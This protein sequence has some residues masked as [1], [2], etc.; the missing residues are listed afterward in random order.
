MAEDEYK[1]LLESVKQHGL[2]HKIVLLDGMILDGRHRDSACLELK[3]PPIYRDYD[4]IIDGDVPVAFVA[5]ENLHRRSLTTSQRAAVAAELEPFFAEAL[6]KQKAARA[7][8]KADK[9]QQQAATPQ[10]QTPAVETPSAAV[11]D[12]AANGGN[13]AAAKTVEEVTAELAEI[14]KLDNTSSVL[15]GAVAR[16]FDK[17]KDE[18]P[19]DEGHP[20][21]EL[22]ERGWVREDARLKELAESGGGTPAGDD[23]DLEIGS[24]PGTSTDD[25]AATSSQEGAGTSADEGEDEKAPK[26]PK[27]AAEAAGAVAGVSPRSVQE[28]K[29]LKEKDPEKFEQVKSGEKSLHKASQEAAAQQQSV[30]PYRQECADLLEASFGEEFSTALKN[31]TVLKTQA[32]L[33]AFMKLTVPH[34]KEVMQFVVK[35]W[36]VDSAIKFL[37]GEFDAGTTLAE[38]TSYANAKGGEAVVEFGNFTITIE[39]S[40]K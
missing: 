12:A 39:K 6:S 10:G 11:A 33:E 7:K 2:R 28:A 32:E 36:K 20:A 18:C 21:R 22:W 17:A 9:K 1:D 13:E 25:E 30:S 31:L 23:D 4:S 8:A 24:K 35:G 37:R 19:H 15:R 26:G 29:S 40:G 5:D 38:L 16:H 34:Q 27:T 14:H 3:I